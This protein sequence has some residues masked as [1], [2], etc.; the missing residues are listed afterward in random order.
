MTENKGLAVRYGG[1]EF[2]ILLFDRTPQDGV[3]LAEQIY[4]EIKDGFREKIARKL[5]QSIDIPDNKKISCSIGIASFHGG[6]KN[7]FELALNHADQMLYYVKRTGKSKYCVYEDH[8][9]N[10]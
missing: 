9:D 8:N 6:S 4:R 3:E 1:D 7:E 2:I 5:N 10:N